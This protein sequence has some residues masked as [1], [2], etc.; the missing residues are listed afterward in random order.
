M[1]SRTLLFPSGSSESPRPASA[2]GASCPYGLGGDQNCPS[3]IL[4]LLYVKDDAYIYNVL[5]IVTKDSYVSKFEV[6]FGSGGS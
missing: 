2:E 1:P 6:K 3:I 5:K 4:I